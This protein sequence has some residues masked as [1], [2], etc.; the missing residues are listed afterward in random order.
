MKQLQK[1]YE[2]HYYDV[3]FSL[4]FIPLVWSYFCWFIYNLVV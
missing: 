4:Y 3:N 2:F 1:L